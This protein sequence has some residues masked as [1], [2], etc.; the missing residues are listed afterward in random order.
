MPAQRKRAGQRLRARKPAAAKV[1]ELSFKMEE[2]L[3]EVIDSVYAL[4][5]MGHGL[6]QLASDEEG[7][8]IAAVAW[9]ACQRLDALQETWRSLCKAAVRARDAS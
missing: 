8:A 4:R 5:L 3:N 2:P 1:V 9:T 7:C 6:T